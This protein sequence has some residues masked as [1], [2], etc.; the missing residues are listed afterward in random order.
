M[1]ASL[2]IIKLI[3]VLKMLLTIDN[4]EIIKCA[5][6]SLIEEL[7]DHQNKNKSDTQDSNEIFD[8]R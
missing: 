8:P 5:L 1:S 6:E 7:E 4:I 2:L 3:N